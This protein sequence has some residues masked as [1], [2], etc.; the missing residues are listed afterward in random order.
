MNKT[1]N[2]NHLTFFEDNDGDEGFD[3]HFNDLDDEG[4]DGHFSS[5]DHGGNSPPKL[6]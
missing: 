3:G 5:L 2:N 6:L 1:M 4:L